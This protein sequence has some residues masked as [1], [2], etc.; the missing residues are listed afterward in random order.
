VMFIF[1]FVTYWFLCEF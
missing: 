1:C